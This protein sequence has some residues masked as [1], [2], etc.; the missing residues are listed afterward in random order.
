[1]PKNTTSTASKCY[2]ALSKAYENLAEIFQQSIANESDVSEVFSEAQAAQQ[3]W[4]EVG[5]HG[6]KPLVG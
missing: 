5:Y 4:I 3:I 2:R 6:S 1:M